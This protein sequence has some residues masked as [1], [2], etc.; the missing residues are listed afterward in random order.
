MRIVHNDVEKAC[1][2]KR[3]L[4]GHAHVDHYNHTEPEA[5]TDVE[6]VCPG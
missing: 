4:M 3:A 6:Q 1:P 5:L 2:I